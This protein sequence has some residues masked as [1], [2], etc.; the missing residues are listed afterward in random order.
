MNVDFDP[1]EN[2][3]FEPIIN[4]S[5]KTTNKSDSELN[6]VI[7]EENRIKSRS[8]LSLRFT[9]LFESLSPKSQ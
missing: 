3:P 6:I 1:L 8:N 5:N 9:N 2:R 4:Q 7:N